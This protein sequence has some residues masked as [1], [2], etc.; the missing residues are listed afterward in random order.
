ME[1]P[2]VERSRRPSAEIYS[3]HH[4]ANCESRSLGLCAELVPE[5]LG[6]IEGRS[7]P[8]DLAAGAMLFEQGDTPQYVYTVL[9]GTLRL[10]ADL[11]D[12][13][14]Q[15]LGFPM[16]GDFFGLT[17]LRYYDYAACALTPSRVCRIGQSSFRQLLLQLQPL[18]QRYHARN[19]EMLCAARSRA[20]AL[21]RKTALERVAG[22]LLE[23]LRHPAH[24]HLEAS[25]DCQ[26]RRAAEDEMARSHSNE[27][28]L[29]MTRADIADYL[30]LTV[31]TISRNLS[32]L[33]K[34]GLIVMSGSD[35]VHVVDPAALVH[36]ADADGRIVPLS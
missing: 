30:G 14:R 36:L 22:F 35:R 4:C 23:C 13:R 12:G 9:H 26:G 33:R 31:E 29:P 34:H 3:L 18:D 5:Q 11:A 28:Y 19:E 6:L 8:F 16:A 24:G 17:A 7:R 20:T 10:S 15:V 2:S 25:E 32:Q 1:T 27:L 21:G